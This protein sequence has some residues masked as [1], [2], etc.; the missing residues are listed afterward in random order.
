MDVLGD[1]IRMVRTGPGLSQRLE[2]RSP[3]A[4][5]APKSIGAVFNV[6]L[7][8]TC[9]IV[10]DDGSLPVALGPGDVVLL[11]HGTP[12]VLADDPRTPA[13]DLAVA[14]TPVHFDTAGLG[15]TG[16]RTLLLSGGYLLDFGRPHPLLA[17][18]PGLLHVPAAPGRHHTLRAAVAMLGDELESGRPG[19]TSVVPALV[20]ALFPLIVRAWV[21]IHTDSVFG[22]WA[23]ALTDPGI[24][25]ALARM[26]AEPERA[27]TVAGLAREV[28]LSRAAFAR[29]FAAA[30]GMPPLAYLTRWRMTIAGRLL[31]ETSL[32][33]GAIAGR[34]GYASE[35]AFAK[36]FKRD[37]GVAPGAYRRQRPDPRA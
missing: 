1:I 33:L 16:A 14:D 34:V 3:W 29:H 5:R 26:H 21:E 30:V 20:D 9:W 28:G 19:G 15:G 32:T 2:I 35:F 24:A 23:E 4:L 6:V 8:G 22:D 7:Q 27:W 10:L 31:L 13:V 25:G 12:H 17:A 11:P 18:L 36:A 37:Y